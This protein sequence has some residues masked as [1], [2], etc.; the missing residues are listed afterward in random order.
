MLKQPHLDKIKEL[1]YT[2]SSFE[3]IKKYLKTQIHDTETIDA[4]MLDANIFISHYR[5]AKQQKEEHLFKMIFWSVVCLG[6]ILLT[7]MSYEASTGRRWIFYGAIL[8]GGALAVQ[9][10][11]DYKKPIDQRSFSIRKK[12]DLKKF[13]SRV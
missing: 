7:I 12:R 10:Y 13:R 2:G 11:K 5:I 1:A 4:L 8:S 9:S 6:G 3:E